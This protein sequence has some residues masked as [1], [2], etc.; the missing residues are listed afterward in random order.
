MEITQG[1]NPQTVLSRQMLIKNGFLGIFQMKSENKSNGRVWRKPCWEADECVELVS[2]KPRVRESFQVDDKNG[3][4]H[5][6]IE[7]LQGL[8][9]LFTAR[10]I[11][12]DRTGKLSRIASLASDLLWTFKN[13]AE[14]MEV[15]T[16]YRCKKSKKV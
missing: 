11:P 3:G 13:K 6:K 2:P 5:P 8:L 15:K 14:N 12:G 10:A 16:Y 9:V 1:H 7:L 4:E